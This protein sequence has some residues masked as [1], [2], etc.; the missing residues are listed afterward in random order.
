MGSLS[1]WAAGLTK[2]VYEHPVGMALV[3]LGGFS[4]GLSQVT[5]F[6]LRDL[7]ERWK[8][9]ASATLSEEARS[10]LRARVRNLASD[11]SLSVDESQGLRE[12]VASLK[13]EAQPAERY[14]SEIEPRM[15]QAARDLQEGAELAA[16]ERFAEAR[17]R[18]REATRLDGESATTWANFGGAALELGAVAE[19]EAALR[20]ALALEPENIE[21]NY[22]FGACL[23]VQDRGAAALDHLERSLSL[24]LRRDAPP[25]FARQALLDDLQKSDHFASLRG[26]PRFAAL[27]RRIHDD[28]H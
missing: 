3:I 27:I 22:N 28:F 12:Y 15:L 2:F 5:G 21:A 26:S 10:A 4:V 18:F 7:A 1:R 11:G 24:L 16:Q 6:N 20:K 14:L 17:E 19:A 13:L 8:P 23:A 9:A 25:T